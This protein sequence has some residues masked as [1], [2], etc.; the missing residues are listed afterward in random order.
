MTVAEQPRRLAVPSATG[1]LRSGVF[2]TALLVGTTVLAMDQAIGRYQASRL[3]Q[4]RLE[5]LRLQHAAFAGLN[6]ELAKIGYEPDG[7][8]YRLTMTITNLNPAQAIYVMLSPVRV[9]EQVGLTWKEVPARAADTARL[10]RLTSRHV[11]ETVFEPNLK[12]WAQ[13]MPGY[14]HIRFESNRLISQRSEPDDDIVE[15]IDRTYV[16][17]K[18]HDADDETIRKAMKYRGDPPVY[19]P[20]PPH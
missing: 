19:I 20:M 15:R 1:L 6:V 16:Y 10:V 9:F 11:T 7:K 4:Q 8:S 13:L 14:M 17:L 3:E 12:D 2:I 5:S 18:P